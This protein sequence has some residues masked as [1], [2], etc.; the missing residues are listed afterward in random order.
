MSSKQLNSDKK[1]T[2]SIFCLTS[3]SLYSWQL[4]CSSLSSL[5]SH[6]LTYKRMMMKWNTA[7]LCVAC[8]R[9][10][11][12]TEQQS[13][14]L[15]HQYHLHILTSPTP[16]GDG[17]EHLKNGSSHKWT[18]CI[19]NVHLDNYYKIIYQHSMRRSWTFVQS[20]EP[21]TSALIIIY[22]MRWWANLTYKPCV[23][24]AFTRLPHSISD[25]I[26]SLKT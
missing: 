19:L 11:S 5:F 23:S 17:D 16:P 24:H 6:V 9:D 8:P 7:V 14:Q 26:R 12:P 4:N 18:N 20:R 13:S 2:V 1:Q 25:W 21:G 15:A 3:V 22:G 10:T